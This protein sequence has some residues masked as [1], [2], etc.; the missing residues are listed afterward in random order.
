MNDTEVTEKVQTAMIKQLANRGFAT[1]I[2]ILL[3]LGL[4]TK[5][6]YELWRKG[7]VSYL[8]KVCNTNLKKLATVMQEM[9]AYAKKAN[10]KLSVCIY[11]G[12]GKSS[13]FLKFSKSGSPNIEKSY[14][15]HFV[16]TK[17]CKESKA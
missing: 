8:E 14:A 16:D 9:R 10:L 13:A 12:Y 11:K 1:P 4:L 5:A 2:D 15:T 7:Q 17:F 6:N 3:D